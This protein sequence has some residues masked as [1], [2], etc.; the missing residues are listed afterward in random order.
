M[1][2][3]PPYAEAGQRI[4]FD[5]HARW[6]GADRAGHR[7]A[8]VRRHGGPFGRRAARLFADPRF[9]VDR[10]T[11]P[12]GLLRHVAP[13]AARAQVPETLLRALIRPEAAL[14]RADRVG[15]QL[16]GRT[17]GARRRH[18]RAAPGPRR[19]DPWPSSLSRWF[20]RSCRCPPWG[21]P[22]WPWPENSPGSRGNGALQ[23][24][25]RGLPNNVTTEMDL[26]LWSLAAAIR[27]DPASAAVFGGSRIARDG[28]A[29][30]G[31]RPARR[32]AVRAA[33]LPG[34]VRPPRRGG[35]RPRHAPLV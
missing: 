23:E 16:R 12:G 24:V 6:S 29:L 34:P 10:Q 2:G 27:N 9:S 8:G 3:P 28:P 11:T 22:C 7:P 33:G 25:L 14:R 4:F 17:G 13:V 32:R 26:D 5:S 1:T 20:P 35:D 21:S 18:R 31:G 15:E 30:P 19:A